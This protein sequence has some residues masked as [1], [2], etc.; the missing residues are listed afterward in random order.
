MLCILDAKQAM[1][2]DFEDLI[3]IENSL[4]HYEAHS[5]SPISTSVI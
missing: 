3:E 2:D 1:E 5:K 4:G